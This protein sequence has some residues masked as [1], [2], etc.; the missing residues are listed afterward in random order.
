MRKYYPD[1]D[2]MGPG[3]AYEWREQ[4]HQIPFINR[5]KDVKYVDWH[6]Y[7]LRGCSGGNIGQLMNSGHPSSSLSAK[8]R[9][10]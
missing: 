3:Y 2:L 6:R 4:G 7:E 10:C 1:T 9:P 5:F 8:F